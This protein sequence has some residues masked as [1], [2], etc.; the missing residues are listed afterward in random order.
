MDKVYKRKN[1]EM[2]WLRVK[3]NAGAGGV[4]EQSVEDFES[5]LEEQLDRLHAELRDGKYEP[6]PVLQQLI[7]KSGQPGKFRP[8]GIPTIYDRVCQQALLNRLE[9]IFESVFDAASFGY[10]RGRSTKDALR[11]IWKELAEGY[12]W[13]VDADLK[14]FFGTVEH[15]KLLTLVGQRVSDSRVL[16]LIEQ[17]L[18][19]GCIAEGKR[20]ATEQ[21][22]PQGGV[23]SPILSNI[24]L[25]PFDGEMR[26]RGYRLTRYADDW[27]V[28]CRTRPEAHQ[29]LEQAKR[30]LAELGVTLNESKTHI[31]H[32]SRGFEFLGYKIKRGSRRLALPSSK[33]RSGTREGDLYAY[34]REKSIQHFKD[35]IRK[36]TRRKAPVDTQGLIADINPVIRGWGLYFCKAHVRKLFARL[37]RWILRRIW[38]HRSKRWRCRGWKQLPERRLYSEMGLVRLVFL[39]PSLNLR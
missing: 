30:I 9:P 11:K 13:I 5:R 25:T 7:P 2:A 39:I 17:M 26:R 4:D 1:L 34:P 6:L 35:Q 37:D 22:T 28:T 3:R 24:L 31:V 20:L 12:E 19:A 27:V 10:R 18:K 33:I 16:R 15:E 23:V 38:S 14:N 8:L 36:R 21:G 32:V 29:A